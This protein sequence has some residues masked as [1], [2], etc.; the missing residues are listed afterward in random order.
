MY[1]LTPT[2]KRE[3]TPEQVQELQDAEAINESR[4]SRS[5]VMDRIYELEGEVTPRRLREHSLGTDNGWLVNQEALI[6][7]ERSKL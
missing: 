7:A 2:G 4:K 1:A 6:E 5:E 3:Y